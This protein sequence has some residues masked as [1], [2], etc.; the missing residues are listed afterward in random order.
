M[1]DINKLIFAQFSTKETVN[2]DFYVRM[3]FIENNCFTYLEPVKIILFLTGYL[4]T[5]G[6]QKVLI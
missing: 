4:I 1:F 3:S 2:L 5:V 6:D